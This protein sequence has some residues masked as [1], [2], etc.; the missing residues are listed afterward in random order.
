MYTLITSFIHPF[1][2]LNKIMMRKMK[3]KGK[4]IK[5]LPLLF[6]SYIENN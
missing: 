4:K 6:Q 5:T 1:L 2:K 3:Q